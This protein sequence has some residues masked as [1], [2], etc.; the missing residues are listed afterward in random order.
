MTFTLSIENDSIFSIDR[1]YTE[2]DSPQLIDYC[3]FVVGELGCLSDLEGFA[4]WGIS[5]AGPT[6]EGTSKGRGQTK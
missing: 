3:L 5:P 2:N 1:F 6:L 4:V